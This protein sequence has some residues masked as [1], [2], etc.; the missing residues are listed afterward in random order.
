MN[1]ELGF[2]EFRA[3][4][5]FAVLVHQ[6]QAAPPV[7]QW[8]PRHRC[9]VT[10]LG[11]ARHSSRTTQLTWPPYSSQQ[12]KGAEQG[13][14][15]AAC[16]GVLDCFPLAAEV[17][18]YRLSLLPCFTVAEKCR[19]HLPVP[20]SFHLL[21]IREWSSILIPEAAKTRVTDAPKITRSR[22]RIPTRS[23]CRIIWPTRKYQ[24]VSWEEPS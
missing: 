11:T 10:D 15:M 6:L 5:P 23:Q 7:H 12:N 4:Y 13:A 14:S 3:S 20:L 18:F 21:R 9:A 1:L 2:L 22:S 19:T 24:S 8:P 16:S 17:S